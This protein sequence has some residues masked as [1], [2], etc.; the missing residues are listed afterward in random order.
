MP[1]EIQY[2]YF[3]EAL[4]GCNK[5]GTV[6]QLGINTN[7]H[8]L[9]PISHSDVYPLPSQGFLDTTRPLRALNGS[10]HH[11]VSTSTHFVHS[12]AQWMRRWPI[13]ILNT[14]DVCSANVTQIY[15]LF[16]L[17]HCSH[18]LPSQKFKF[19]QAW[20]ISVFTFFTHVFIVSNSCS[21]AERG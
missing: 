13:C 9:T 5:R 21:E 8:S 20:R 17:T 15:N 4:L 3:P 7:T 10:A 12:L 6:C 14:C 2:V 1:S 16:I 19:R 18:W 11:Q